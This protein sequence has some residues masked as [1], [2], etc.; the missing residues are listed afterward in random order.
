MAGFRDAC[1]FLGGTIWA[2]A[3]LPA[4]PRAFRFRD[5]ALAFQ[6]ASC[7]AL[8]VVSGIGLLLGVIL[9]FES[10]AALKAFGAEV[11]VSDMLTIG[12]FREL[13]PLVTAIVLAGRTGS[14]FAAE[15]ATMKTNEELDA[16]AT[17]GLE[18]VRF[19]VPPRVAAAVLAMP[20]L[21]IAAELAGL[22]GG[23]GVLWTMGVP[24]A[25]FW[26]RSAAATGA[27]AVA[28]GFS[29][30]LL[31]GMLAGLVGCCAGMNAPPTADGAGSAATRAVVGGIVAI[32]VA[33]GILAVLCHVWNI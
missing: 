19:L 29:K 3:A 24:P 11:Y 32:G 5:F 26:E 8:P 6:R 20:L 25:V 15:I 4:R 17:M 12:L 7:E 28:L 9:A 1:S 22:A 14:A 23:A 30:S 27:A 2:F 10:A 13:G 16:L 18:P 21:T 33:D 31:F